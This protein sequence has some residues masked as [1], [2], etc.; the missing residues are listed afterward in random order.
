MEEK[1]SINIISKYRQELMG[2]SAL[3]ILIF[4][5]WQLIF[6]N[7]PILCGIEHFIKR[8]GYSGVDIFFMLSGI[9]LTYSIKKSG[10]ISFYNKR[11][12]RLI[13]PFILMA[14]V[15]VIFKNWNFIEFIKNIFG[16]NFYLKNIYSFL[17]F[18]PAIFT[19]YLIFPP[20]YKLFEKSKNKVVFTLIII[21]IWFGLSNLL[22]GILRS[23]LYG[24]INRIPIFIIGVLIG[25]LN[26][27]SKYKFKKIDWIII[28]T[29]FI[30]GLV[31]LYLTN[32][33]DLKLLVPLSNCFLPTL[34]VAISLS[35]ILSKILFIS[36]QKKL[37]LSL[38]I[39]KILLFYGTI[40][41]EIY[42]I[43]E[44]LGKRIIII[45]NNYFPEFITNIIFFALVTLIA[46]IISFAEK[47]FWLFI[48]N[49]INKTKKLKRN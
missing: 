4:H 12:K 15:N 48:D 29:M 20:Y 44:W 24:F 39:R 17:W 34:L 45:F 22:S 9:G 3:W 31:T 28:F 32:Y 14:L 2:L 18:V 13:F 8:I 30:L 43:Q 26:Q 33:K 21:A 10:L 49:F 5:E 36:E 27:N 7:I 25:W 41:L 19:L 46:Y 1:N 6:A 40:S 37:K 23:D 47:Q 35:L 11:L 16:I 42:C 38:G